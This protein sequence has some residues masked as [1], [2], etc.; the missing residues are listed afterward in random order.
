MKTRICLLPELEEAVPAQT[1]RAGSADSRRRRKLRAVDYRRKRTRVSH[2]IACTYNCHSVSSATQLLALIDQAQWIKYDVIGLSVTKSKE[3]LA[4]TWNNGT[5]V[6]LGARKPG[7]TSGGVGL[8]V[9]PNFAKNIISATFH[10]HW[11]A[12]LT[13]SLSKDFDV[14]II[15][16]YAP[17]ADPDEEEHEQ[18]YS[19]L[20]DLVRFKKSTFV[21]VMGDFNARIGPWKVGWRSIYWTELGRAKKRGYRK[22]RELLWNAPSIPRKQS[23]CKES[24]KE[25]HIRVSQWSALSRT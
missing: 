9:A 1:G 4:C 21:V 16:A 15:Q 8:I 19:D 3:S 7:T 20:G 10:P 2:L 14:S 6:F 13:V 17:T 23:V 25:M 18:F 12:V 24:S 22:A 11:L 5:A